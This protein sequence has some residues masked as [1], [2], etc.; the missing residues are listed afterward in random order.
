[1]QGAGDPT[2]NPTQGQPN[3]EPHPDVLDSQRRRLFDYF[4]NPDATTPDVQQ[5]SAEKRTV[6]FWMAATKKTVSTLFKV[7]LQPNDSDDESNDNNDKA[8]HARSATREGTAGKHSAKK[9]ESEVQAQAKEAAEK[10]IAPAGIQL[11]HEVL[12]V[13]KPSNCFELTP[14]HR[15][16]AN[17]PSDMRYV[18]FLRGKNNPDGQ[19]LTKKTVVAVRCN[20]HFE[21]GGALVEGE[22]A[23]VREALLSANQIHVFRAQSKHPIIIMHDFQ[24]QQITSPQLRACDA[25]KQRIQFHTKPAVG[26]RMN[27]ATRDPS[28]K[29]VRITGSAAVVDELLSNAPAEWAAIARDF[30]V[31]DTKTLAAFMTGDERDAVAKKSVSIELKQHIVR[32]G[33]ATRALTIRKTN[34]STNAMFELASRLQMGKVIPGHSKCAT[35]TLRTHGTLRVTLDAVITP[36]IVKALREALPDHR[37]FTDTPINVWAGGNEAAPHTRPRK[38]APVRKS[39]DTGHRLVRIAAD[40]EPHPS[41]FESIAKSLKGKVHNIRE[42]KFTTR[43][44]DALISIPKDTPVDQMI[45]QGFAIDEEGHWTMEPVGVAFGDRQPVV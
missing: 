10:V 37:I 26:V 35:S 19:K 27:L 7:H 8:S 38:P 39:I 22:R 2:P 31:S 32:S 30:H 33:H 5:A 11:N 6:A 13:E 44:M 4:N 45:D 14:F 18:K 12:G 42:P 3:D 20:E 36:E 40:Y 25:A 16:E 15:R 43:A 24:E 28:R 41:A 29:E 23:Y 1:M 17:L 21:D 34:A 9:P